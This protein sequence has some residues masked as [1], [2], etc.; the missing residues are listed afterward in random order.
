M[1]NS[2]INIVPISEDE[3]DAYID[4]RI[5]SYAVEL[6][7]AEI[8]RLTS[9]E[10]AMKKAIDLFDELFPQGY[11]TTGYNFSRIKLDDKIIG[12]VISFHGNDYHKSSRLVDIEIIQ[13]FRN[14]GIGTHVVKTVLQEAKSNDSEYISL[15][16]FKHSPRSKNLYER[17]GFR[18]WKEYD[19][20]YYLFKH[21]KPLI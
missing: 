2:S 10:M 8:D 7:K 21:L 15:F 17:L 5:K 6:L 13:E 11:H 19:A 1:S 12:I 20:G 14:Q 3:Y 9:K 18:E 4:Q 16:V